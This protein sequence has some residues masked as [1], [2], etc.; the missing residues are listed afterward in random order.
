MVNEENYKLRMSDLKPLGYGLRE[1]DNRNP[2]TKGLDQNIKIVSRYIPL[3]FY[4]LGTIL[5]T[6]GVI[7]KSLE[8]IL[9]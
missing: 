9:N 3:T 8:S 6:A 1:Y 5:L 4:Q 2:P 7:V